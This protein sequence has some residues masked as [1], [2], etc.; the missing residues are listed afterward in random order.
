MTAESI[1][2]RRLP[3]MGASA[4]EYHRLYEGPDHLLLV[5]SSGFTESYRRFYFRDIQDFT[6]RKTARGKVW[7]GIWGT[8]AVLSGSIAMQMDEAAFIIWWVVAAVFLTLMIVNVAIGP[9][10]ICQI[11]TAV[12]TRP[13]APLKRLRRAQKVIARLRPQI[14]SV[15]APMSLQELQG[16][17]ELARQGLSGE[18]SVTPVAEPLIDTPQT[19]P[20]AEATTPLPPESQANPS[21]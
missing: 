19:A 14:E 15:Q 21:A 5:A 6:L 12:Q 10:C 11:R 16:R 13:L 2:Y 1:A 17:I 20:S 4:V 18:R 8:L 7:N 3:G 9:T